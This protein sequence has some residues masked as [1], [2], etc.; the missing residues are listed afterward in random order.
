MRSAVLRCPRLVPRLGLL[1]EKARQPAA[2]CVSFVRGPC[3]KALA[4][5]HAKLTG[6]DL[7]AEERVRPCRAVEVAIKHL[8]DVDGEVQADQ[9]GLLHGTEYGGPRAESFAHDG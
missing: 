7:V 4:G 2:H 5:F 8:G 3:P 6:L 1:G 9:I